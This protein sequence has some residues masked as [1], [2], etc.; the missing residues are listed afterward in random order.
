MMTRSETPLSAL[1]EVRQLNQLFLE[2]LREQLGRNERF[3][4]PADAAQL[5]LTASPEQIDQAARFPRALFRLCLPAQ[6]PP[7]ML[8]PMALA[9]GTRGQVLKLILLNAARNFSRTSGYSARLLL[10]LSDDE[11][12]RFRAAEVDQIVAWSRHEGLVSAAFD[13]LGWLWRELLTEDRPEFRRRLL[14]IG[15]QPDLSV[16][17]ATGFA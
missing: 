12:L 13:D 1:D 15:L 17:P 5:L 10:R 7:P 8:A 14:L 2:F 6:L 4:L 16:S 9:P 11:V 3:G